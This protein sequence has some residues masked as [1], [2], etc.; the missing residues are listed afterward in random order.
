MLV[1][2]VDRRVMD[3]GGRVVVGGGLVVCGGAE[4]DGGTGAG[5]ELCLNILGKE[6]GSG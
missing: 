6:L 3:G 4:A 5:A 2:S 1:E